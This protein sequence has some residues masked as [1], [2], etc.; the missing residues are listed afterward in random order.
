MRV[1]S[2]LLVAVALLTL[3]VAPARADA[4]PMTRASCQSV[5]A[6]APWHLLQS[7]GNTRYASEMLPLHRPSL[8]FNGF[9]NTKDGLTPNAAHGLPRHRS[10]ALT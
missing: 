6:S 10:G 3:S 7:R 8:T 2:T 9:D 4:P 1:V 5:V